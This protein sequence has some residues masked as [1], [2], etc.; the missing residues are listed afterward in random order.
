MLNSIL[1]WAQTM[2]NSW[3]I[4]GDIYDNYDRPDPRCP[5]TGAEDYNCA[6]PGFHCSMINILDK[7]SHIVD[8]GIPG[9]WNDL[10][11]LE[12]GNGGM[13]DD[14]YK[15]HFTMWAAVKSPLIMGNDI[16]ALGPSAF[17]I[18]ANPAILAIS[19]D[20]NGGSVVRRWRYYVGDTDA[21]G[22]GQIS[23]WSGSLSGGDY[24][25]ILVNG[26][27][28]ERI[29]NA[30]LSDIF[31]D[32][33]G[34]QAVQAKSTSWDLHDLWANRMDNATANMVL[35][36]NSTVGVQALDKYYYNA[37]AMSYAEGL[38]G[39]NSLLM[40]TRTGSVAPMGTVLTTVARHGVAAYRMRP[41]AGG[42][43]KRNE[44]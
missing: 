32:Q 24:I 23:M 2:S 25:V 44:L 20:T 35:N 28:D 38:A 4:S 19:Q 9:A 26:G 17:S 27:N 41:A 34:D 22:L 42:M 39:N 1:Q 14:E 15:T 37:T 36:D 43:Y 7:V 30:T 3:R 31:I 33:G 29:M 40:G 11:A 16:R 13:T 10:D 8:K 5:C 12:V 6:L 18:L 21:N